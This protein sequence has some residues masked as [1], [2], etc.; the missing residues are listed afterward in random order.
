MFRPFPFIFRGVQLSELKKKSFSA[1][2]HWNPIILFHVRYVGT[3]KVN[4]LDTAVNFVMP[5]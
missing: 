4:R 5:Q 1:T 3:V 2:L